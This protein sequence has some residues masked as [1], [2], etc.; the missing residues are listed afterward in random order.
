MLTLGATFFVIALLYALVGFGGGT[1]YIAALAIAGIPYTMIPKISLLCNL[2]VVSGGCWHYM[3]AGHFDRKLILP[4]VLS[5]VPLSFLGGSFPLSE[6][7]FYILLTVSLCL[8]GIRI[9]FIRDRLTVELQR[10]GFVT[11]LIAGGLL[12]FL[13]GMVGIGGGIFLS[14]LLINMGW[15]RSKEAAAV[16]SMFIFLNSLAGLVG[17][18]SKDTMLPDPVTYLPLFLAVIMG[19][20]IGSRLGTHSRISYQIIQKGTGLL[21]LFIGSRLLL[22]YIT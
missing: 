5:S 2:L 9:L 19:G 17:Q 12:G 16:A 11:S 22:K 1:S 7:T 20:Q 13:S 8:C 18:F 15:A 6:K 10:P 21:T 4:F 3:R 14:P